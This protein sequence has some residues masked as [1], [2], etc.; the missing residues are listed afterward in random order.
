MSKRYNI[1]ANSVRSHTAKS[2]IIKPEEHNPKSIM[3]ID[4]Y[5]SIKPPTHVAISVQ[6]RGTEENAA[7]KNPL[8]GAKTVISSPPNSGE[9]SFQSHCFTQ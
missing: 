2:H 9:L 4:T 5:G 3:T 7:A 1:H 8:L 6:D